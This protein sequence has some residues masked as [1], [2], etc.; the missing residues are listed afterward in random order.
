MRL[1]NNKN[2]KWGITAK[3]VVLSVVSVFIA[4]LAVKYGDSQ[5]YMVLAPALVGLENFV[6]HR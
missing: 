3:R 5:W 6:S 4:G 2:F 1:V